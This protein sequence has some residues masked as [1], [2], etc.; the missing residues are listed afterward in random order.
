MSQILKHTVLFAFKDTASEQDIQSV[1]N[2]F[3]KLKHEIDEVQDLEWVTN[4]SI[5]NLDQ[6]FTHC[7][8]LSFLSEA[9]RNA[10]LP[11]P[12]HQAFG[13]L[14][15]PHLDKVLVVDYWAQDK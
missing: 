3:A 13:K 8:Q 6:G 5:E 14:L 11:H 7:F 4:V 10:Y 12:A 9:D 2:A 1:V 15:A